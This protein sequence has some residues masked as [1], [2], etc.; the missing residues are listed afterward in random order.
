[1]KA[2]SCKPEGQKTKDRKFFS[3]FLAENSFFDLGGCKSD[4]LKAD[5]SQPFVSIRLAISLPL[6]KEK[7]DGDS[8]AR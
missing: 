2:T 8:N 4:R 5:A 3:W 1:M 7:Y 6:P